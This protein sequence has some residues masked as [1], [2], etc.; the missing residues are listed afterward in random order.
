M[1]HA[2]ALHVAVVLLCGVIAGGMTPAH[3]LLLCAKIDKAGELKDGAVV[4]L[5][6]ACKTKKDG[7]PVELAIGTTKDLMCGNGILDLG[8]ECDYSW[9]EERVDF[10]DATCA[11]RGFPSGSLRCLA[12]SIDDADCSQCGNGILDDGEE[13]DGADLGGQD[14][15]T[16]PGGFI[17]GDLSCGSDCRLNSDSCTGRTC[18]DMQRF[19]C[20]GGGGPIE[21]P[22]GCGACLIDAGIFQMCLNGCSSEAGILACAAAVRTSG[23]APTCRCF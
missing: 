21:S 10:G 5:R 4:K 20:A 14:C 22:I 19:E 11:S 12:C 23:C 1:R 13:C 16:I 18:E 6:E 9:E 8:E 15:T 17:G 3:A 7:T 2:V